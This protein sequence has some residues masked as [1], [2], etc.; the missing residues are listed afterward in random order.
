MVKL[1]LKELLQALVETDDKDQRFA[2]VEENAELM[3]E[4]E[5]PAT[6][7]AEIEQ[8]KQL[9]EMEKAA[10]DETKRKYRERF[11]AEVDETETV[12]PAE[13]TKEITIEDLVKKGSE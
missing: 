1:T 7:P 8:Y 4:P 9:Y 11:F 6:D 12:P 13:E 2:L 3:D 10:H 5:A